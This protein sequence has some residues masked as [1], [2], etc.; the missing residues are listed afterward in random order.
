[1]VLFNGRLKNILTCKRLPMILV[2][3]FI[4]LFWFLP[5]TDLVYGLALEINPSQRVLVSLD[6]KTG[7]METIGRKFTENS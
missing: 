3:N 7:Q 1:M 4:Y 5:A 2:S 6:S